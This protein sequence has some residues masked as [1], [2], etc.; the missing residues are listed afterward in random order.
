M[1]SIE[2]MGLLGG[3]K[4]KPRIAAIGGMG[5]CRKYYQSLFYDNMQ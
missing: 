2:E 5:T 4:I 1:E 3:I